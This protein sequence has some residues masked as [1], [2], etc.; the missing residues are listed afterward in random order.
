M[1][2]GTVIAQHSGDTDPTTEGFTLRDGAS[3]SPL[4]PDPAYPAVNAW[5]TVTY[6]QYQYQLSTEENSQALANGY[7]V[8]ATL[9]IDTANMGAGDEV[10]IFVIQMLNDDDEG[11]WY[12]VKF[13][14]DVNKI[15]TLYFYN[16]DRNY[17]AYSYAM[18]DAG[19][20]T[21]TIAYDGATGKGDLLVDGVVVFDD[22]GPDIA[23]PAL[24]KTPYGR[25]SFGNTSGLSGT[26]SNWSSLEFSVVPEPATLSLL[27]LGGVLAFRRR[28]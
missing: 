21:Y 12:F 15:P 24:T 26:Q 14:T 6:S 7:T 17:E 3:G 9:R 2:Y 19:Y 22:V 1:S 5:A 13:S 11:E 23:D 18:S 16:E 28:R 4:T 25:V 20:H 10:A 27:T 8:S